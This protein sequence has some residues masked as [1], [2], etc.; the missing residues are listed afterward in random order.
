MSLIAEIPGPAGAPVTIRHARVEDAPALLA[1]LRVVGG[2]SPYLTFGEEGP[3]LTEEEERA[4]LTRVDTSDNAI[5]LIAEWSGQIV[6]S[7]TFSGGNR[8]RLRHIGEFGISV[9]RVCQGF[10]VGRRLIELLIDW[11]VRGGVVRKINLLVRSDNT[12]AVALYESF[13]FVIEGRIRR[14]IVVGG[15]FFDSF[16]MGRLIDPD[17]VSPAA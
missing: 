16:L 11:A 10:G 8:P 17:T 9:A 14:E 3:P 5:V 12:R 2:E 4:F 6:G 13:G 1:Y 15:E 7:L